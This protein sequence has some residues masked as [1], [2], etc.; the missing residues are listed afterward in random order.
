MR[1]FESWSRVRPLPVALALAGLT[2]S[3]VCAAVEEYPGV[4]RAHLQLTYEPPCS[5]CHLKG[6][7]GP[8]TV[9]TPVGIAL[10]A[11]G[12]SGHDEASLGRAVDALAS[13]GTDSDGDGASDVEELRAQVDPN[14]P[15]NQRLDSAS[16][17][18]FGCGGGEDEYQRGALAGPLVAVAWL[19]RRLRSA[20]RR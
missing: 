1:I 19:L 10:R 3:G 11:R 20:R 14:S 18:T 4:V 7:T 6:N 15:G 12:M 16:D 13:D 17:P 9:Q 2:S 8:G 5:V